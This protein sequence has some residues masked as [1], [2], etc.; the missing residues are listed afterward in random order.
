MDKIVRMVLQARREMAIRE[1]QAFQDDKDRAERGETMKIGTYT[2]NAVVGEHG[3]TLS[4]EN[5]GTPTFV[6]TMNIYIPSDLGSGVRV[7]G[8]PVCTQ[9]ELDDRLD[10]EKDED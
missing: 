7:E 10:R 3:I 9:D 6:E 8:F 4:I 5:S 1:A 2:I